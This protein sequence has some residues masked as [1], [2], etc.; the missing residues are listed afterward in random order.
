MKK[1][2]SDV[3]RGM[4]DLVCDKCR[5]KVRKETEKLSSKDLLHPKRL[6]K[7]FANLLC[8]KCRRKVESRLRR[9]GR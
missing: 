3:G 6:S 1:D 4:M 8:D 2:Y 7:R 9:G 5:E